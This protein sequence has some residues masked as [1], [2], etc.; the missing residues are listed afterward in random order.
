MSCLIQTREMDT[1]QPFVR[2]E[3][4]NYY[5]SPDDLP[6]R[7]LG[8]NFWWIELGGEYDS[9]HDT[10]VLRDMLLKVSYGVWDLLKNRSEQAEALT[11]YALDWVGHL[12]GK[13]ESRRCVGDHI[14]TQNDVRAE[15]RFD[16]L[17]AYGGWSMDDHHPAGIATPEK[18]TIFHPAPSPYGI[19]YRALYSKN[20]SNLFFAGR[21][22][23]ATHA[24][25]S[26]TRVMA[27]CAVMGQAVGTAASIA[28]AKSCSPRDVYSESIQELQQALMEDDCYLPWHIR[29]VSELTRSATL[30]AEEGE[31]ELLRNGLDRP[32]DE[33][34]N[35]WDGATG[36]WIEYRFDRPTQIS[37][38]RLVFDSNLN[39]GAKNMPFVHKLG[40]ASRCVPD[41]LVK[42]FRIEACSEDG[43]WATVAEVK[44]NHQRLVKLDLGVTATAIR[45]IPESTWGAAAAHLFAFDI[46]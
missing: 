14:I 17:V 12:P 8:H 45:L 21:N 9:I 7:N 46:R 35:S 36:Q 34:S 2:P 5:D 41:T 24:A 20:I 15:G 11:N 3:W 10:E 31:A 38:T 16:D 44:D 32:I 27:T 23:S 30:T 42:S 1:P 25:M 4:A 39:R 28:V 40:Q 6:H 43:S 29:E 13:R 37:A 26:S 18:P 33:N 19:P 22:I